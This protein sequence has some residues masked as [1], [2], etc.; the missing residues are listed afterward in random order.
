[1]VMIT[2]K[3]LQIKNAFPQFGDQGRHLHKITGFI[4]ANLFG[5]IKRRYSNEWNC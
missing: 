5:E 2:L 4:V 1:M 3:S